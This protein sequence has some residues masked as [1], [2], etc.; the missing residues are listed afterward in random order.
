[1]NVHVA[2]TLSN[3]LILEYLPD[4]N[5]HRSAIVNEPMRLVE[6]FLQL[7]DEPGLGIDLNEEALGQFPFKPWHRPFLFWADGSITY[8]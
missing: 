8:Q 7:P 1:M 3:F 6:G 4:D 2:A 5:P